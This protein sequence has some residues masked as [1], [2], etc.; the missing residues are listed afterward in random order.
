MSKRI[1]LG[2]CGAAIGQ[3]AFGGDGGFSL[4]IRLK[5]SQSE[6]TR[7]SDREVKQVRTNVSAG[8][9]APSI[10]GFTSTGSKHLWS[11]AFYDRR[12]TFKAVK[13]LSKEL[14]VRE[15]Q[16]YLRLVLE[17]IDRSRAEWKRKAQEAENAQKRLKLI[18]ATNEESKLKGLRPSILYW[19]RNPREGLSF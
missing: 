5:Y 12:L 13:D 17:D 8:Q 2:A 6:F 19:Y 15:R 14:A 18:Q 4:S 1:F 7:V 11:S 3:H 10:S 16:D 9:A